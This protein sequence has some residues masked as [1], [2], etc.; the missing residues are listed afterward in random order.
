MLLFCM[1]ELT[2]KY[3]IFLSFLCLHNLLY[4]DIYTDDENPRLN[5]VRSSSRGQFMFF[6]AFIY[7]IL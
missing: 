4:V 7:D 5:F 6:G 1:S 2:K 3:L